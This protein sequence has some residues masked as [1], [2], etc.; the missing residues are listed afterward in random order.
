MT[1]DEERTPNEAHL[2]LSRTDGLTTMK[3]SLSLKDHDVPAIELLD[4][5]LERRKRLNDQESKEAGT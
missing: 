5:L 1:E 4:A 2:A 3:V